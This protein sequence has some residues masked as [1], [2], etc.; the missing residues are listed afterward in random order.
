MKLTFFLVLLFLSCNAVQAQLVSK[1]PQHE[2]VKFYRKMIDSLPVFIASGITTAPNIKR[3]CHTPGHIQYFHS[4]YGAYLSGRALN[5]REEEKDAFARTYSFYDQSI[6]FYNQQDYRRS[7]YYCQQALET[8]IAHN[9][10]FEELHLCRPSLNNSYFLSG[11]YT[12]AM[13]I[14]SAGLSKAGQIKDTNR[15]AHFNNVIG[16]IHMRQKNFVEAGQYFQLNLQLCRSLND[17]LSEAGALCNLSELCIARGQYDKAIFF[18]QAAD[19]TYRSMKDVSF[20]T[21]KEREAY[22]SN[23]MAEAYKLKGACR[24]ALAFAL[25][26]TFIAGQQLGGMNLY[27]E[28][29]Y[30]INTGAIYNCLHNPDSAVFFLRQGIRVAKS[31]IHRE[32]IRDA[33]EQLAIA[34]AGQKI[35]DS[36]YLYHSLFARLKDSINAE[37]S[38]QEILQREA[39]LK[40]EQQRQL[41]QSAMEQQKL[42]RNIIIGTSIFALVTLV[43][44]Y[45]RYRL[46]QK[47]RYQQEMNRQQNELFNAIAATQDQERKRIA[48][49]IHDSLGS[50]LSAAKLKLSA[51]KES[52][53][54]M[55]VDQLENYQVAMQLLDEA[56]GELRNISHNIM[57]ATLSKLGLIAAL[58]N[59]INH[60]TSQ[61]GIQ[62]HFSSH[63]FEQ[64]L[65]EH[66][67]MSIY[68]IV[69]ELIN[70][71]IKHAEASKVTV[72]MI[73]HPDYINLSVEDNGRGFDYENALKI[74][75]GIGL[76]NIISRVEYL[77]GGIDVDTLPGRGTTVI[78]DIPYS[79]V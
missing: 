1:K 6:E 2:R 40:I 35:F 28:A 26:A 78:I 16:Y 25:N 34:F 19:Q 47:N 67:E 14:S 27:D 18:L 15:M 63:G 29:S 65:D 54:A 60:I 74:K 69:L 46:R 48:E 21:P 53:P 37:T 77:K 52:Q 58:R 9:F 32:Y 22:V 44:L 11:D 66:T 42:W 36:A 45:N 50:I 51:L 56:S 10:S 61:A 59:L 17:T 20:F 55:N 62:I 76:G 4:K 68:R 39:S 30:Y 13:K 43:F 31:I 71:I 5:L 41:Q 64:R 7:N 70:N 72:Q 38:Q 79:P 3:Q 75:K 23:K 33:A 8:A 12:N 57:P 24:Q 73:R 49:D